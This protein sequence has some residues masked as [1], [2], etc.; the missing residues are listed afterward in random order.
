MN[1]S[2]ELLAEPFWV[3]EKII[4]FDMSGNIVEKSNWQKF[5]RPVENST[6]IFHVKGNFKAVS[7]PVRIILR[8]ATSVSP[9]VFV[10]M[11]RYRATATNWAY[12]SEAS[13]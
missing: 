2:E 4:Q 6:G 13:F 5:A 11:S 3:K 7:F 12:P 10:H 1:P 9:R 8:M